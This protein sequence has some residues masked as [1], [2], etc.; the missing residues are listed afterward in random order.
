MTFFFFF[1]AEDGIRDYKVTGVQTCALPISRAGVGAGGLEPRASG[2]LAAA[3]PGA[4]DQPRDDLPLHLG[5]QAPGRAVVHP[6]AR[7]AEA[8]AQTLRAL[9]QAGGPWPARPPPPPPPPRP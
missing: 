6:P 5:G 3:P 2:G 4:R 9:R 1:Q 7:R 8:A